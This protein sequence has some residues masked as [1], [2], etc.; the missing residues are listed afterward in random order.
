MGWK[1]C[2]T[3]RMRFQEMSKE[4]T[5]FEYYMK[6]HITTSIHFYMSDGNKDPLVHEKLSSGIPVF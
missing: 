4:R 5:K 3:A 1:A 2:R 6:N